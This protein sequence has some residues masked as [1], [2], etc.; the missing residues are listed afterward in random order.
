MVSLYFP[1]SHGSQEAKVDGN[2]GRNEK[3]EEADNVERDTAD[4]AAIGGLHPEK[5]SL[6]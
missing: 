3:E 1:S 6:E 4:T 5:M 2:V